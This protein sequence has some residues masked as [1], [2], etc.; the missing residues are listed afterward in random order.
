[1]EQITPLV[2]ATREP[3]EHKIQ[4]QTGV[5][6]KPEFALPFPPSPPVVTGS[7]ALRAIFGIGS[8]ATA[9]PFR[10]FAFHQSVGGSS[11]S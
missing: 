7:L 9:A 1:M 11:P 5:G 4:A 2:E 10:S 8:H 3:S 6:V